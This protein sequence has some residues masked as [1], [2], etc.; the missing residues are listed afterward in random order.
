MHPSSDPPWKLLENTLAACTETN[1]SQPCPSTLAAARELHTKNNSKSILV[2]ASKGKC[3][4]SQCS[5]TR[6]GCS[7]KCLA[8]NLC[9]W[10][11]T[12][13][14]YVH[15]STSCCNQKYCLLHTKGENHSNFQ[16]TV[17]SSG[18]K[19]SLQKM[20]KHFLLL[21]GLSIRG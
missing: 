17:P 3:I 16:H 2:M 11:E 20:E 13:H 6:K 1:F 15:C 7:S 18:T 8:I 4:Q 14:V 5:F 9:E 19:L 12:P 10:S 21:I